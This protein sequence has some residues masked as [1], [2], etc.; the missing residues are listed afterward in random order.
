MR[1]IVVSD[2]HGSYEKLEFVIKRHQDADLLIHLGD[3]A[4]ELL[5]LKEKYKSLNMGVVCGNCDPPSLPLAPFSEISVSRHKI[6]ACHGDFYYVT[7]GLTPLLNEAK[8]READIVLY[9]HT[10]KKFTGYQNSIH[11]MNPGSLARPR[12]GSSSYG[13]IDINNG[14][15]IK[16]LVEVE[17][18][19]NE[20]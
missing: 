10:H 5:K 6:F 12:D 17:D 7:A 4:R 3:G 13:I 1:V 14:E 16:K 18:F 8:K 15:V 19:E 20:F 11:I 9:G 2:T